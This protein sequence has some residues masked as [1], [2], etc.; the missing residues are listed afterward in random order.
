MYNFAC[1]PIIGRATSVFPNELQLLT[2]FFAGFRCC[3]IPFERFILF[4]VND[5]YQCLLLS[6]YI[7]HFVLAALPQPSKLF[8]LTLLSFLAG[9]FSLSSDRSASQMDT[10]NLCQLAY[11]D[12][13]HLHVL[14]L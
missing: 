3:R 13:A 5:I 7:F 12:F 2:T 6:S 1:N 10:T 14:Y 8:V 4:E 9:K 11:G